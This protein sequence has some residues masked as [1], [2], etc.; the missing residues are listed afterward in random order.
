MRT[1]SR[2]H[3]PRSRQAKGA[4]THS[5]ARTP[6]APTGTRISCDAERSSARIER[7]VEGFPPLTV[8]VGL[9]DGRT[10]RSR[11]AF[12]R[13]GKSAAG[14][15]KRG[16]V[17]G[18]VCCRALVVGV[19]LFV[20]L[21]SPTLAQAAPGWSATGAMSVERYDHTDTMLPNGKVLVAGGLDDTFTQ[22]LAGA[23][24]YDPTTARWSL[25]A[26]MSV[27]RAEHTATLLADG[28]V[29]VAGGVS[30]DSRPGPSYKLASRGHQAE[31]RAPW[32]FRSTFGNGARGSSR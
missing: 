6:G 32:P 13:N 24:L 1:S 14:F 3:T 26:S 31:S 10:H 29:L 15:I 28:R 18:R 25:T 2:P 19:V 23:E 8:R 20:A 4:V 27:A 11:A 30:Q 12:R 21:A 9:C 5:H 16:S 22:S 7:N 17:M